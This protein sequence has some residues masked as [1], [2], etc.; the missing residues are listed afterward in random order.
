V[1]WRWSQ[2]RTIQPG[3][4]LEYSTHTHGVLMG[5]GF[6]FLLSKFYYSFSYDAHDLLEA[7]GTIES[8]RLRM[9]VE[10]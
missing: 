2:L 5:E 4:A 7:A 1:F 6:F 8:A 10:F 9:L 3:R